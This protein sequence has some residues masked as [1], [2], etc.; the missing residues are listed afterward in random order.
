MLV[1]CGHFYIRKTCQ[2]SCCKV[3][4]GRDWRNP[5]FLYKLLEISCFDKT[6]QLIAS[7]LLNGDISY[8]SQIS[9][10][11]LKT[12]HIC[13]LFLYWALSNFVDQCWEFYHALKIKVTYT[14]PNICYAST[15]EVSKNMPFHF[16]QINTPCL[17]AWFLSIVILNEA[18]AIVL[19]KRKKKVDTWRSIK[20]VRTHFGA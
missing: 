11:M 18:W 15:L 3:R 5:I 13:Y 19:K 10:Y 20:N 8:Q 9:C 7:L 17:L 16:R 4:C 2:L 6:S 12:F 1:T 14:P